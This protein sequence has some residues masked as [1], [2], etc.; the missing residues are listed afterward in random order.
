MWGRA[1]SQGCSH[2]KARLGLEDLLLRGLPHT[3]VVLAVWACPH[4]CLSVVVTP[5]PVS[6]DSK[7][8]VTF[9]VCYACLRSVRCLILCVLLVTQAIPTQLEGTHKGMAIGWGQWDHLG[10]WLCH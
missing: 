9:V 2:L 1:V 6:Q 7:A 4:D 3:T 8:A 10:G 5:E